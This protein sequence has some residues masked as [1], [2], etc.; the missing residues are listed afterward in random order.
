MKVA[1]RI[2]NYQLEELSNNRLFINKYDMSL[3]YSYELNIHWKE[4]FFDIMNELFNTYGIVSF[5]KAT[6]YKDGLFEILQENYEE[7]IKDNNLKTDI[8]DYI[9]L[10]D[11]ISFDKWLEIEG[12][13]IAFYEQDILLIKE[14]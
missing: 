9:E 2:E 13:D 4:L 8:R 12:N 7:V 6:E 11:Y 14:M 1:K 5:K 3:K 10:E